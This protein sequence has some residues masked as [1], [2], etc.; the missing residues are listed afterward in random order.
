MSRKISELVG[1]DDILLVEEFSSDGLIATLAEAYHSQWKREKIS[2]GWCFAETL[3]TQLK[4]HPFLCSYLKLSETAKIQFF[5][6]AVESFSVKKSKRINGR[7]DSLNSKA[8]ISNSEPSSKKLLSKIL[9]LSNSNTAEIT[10]FW[11][12]HDEKAWKSNLEAYYQFGRLFLTKAEPLLAYD[13]FNEGLKAAHLSQ[14]NT[15]QNQ[16]W[17]IKI[18]QQQALALAESGA[19]EE[20]KKI[21]HGLMPFGGRLERE[22]DSETLGLLGR[23]YKH[24]GLSDELADKSKAEYFVKSY[25]YYYK[26][27]QNAIS[28]S[29]F[30]DA[31]YSGINAATVAL[32]CGKRKVSSELAGE[33]IFICNKLLQN[34]ESEQCATS[35]WLLGSLAEAQLLQCNLQEAN[36][37]YH[38]A[39]HLMKDDI[40][41]QISMY[42]QAKSICRALKINSKSLDSL[43]RV[44]TILC[45][46]VKLSEAI[47]I[48]NQDIE[49][50]VLEKIQQQIEKYDRI[51]AYASAKNAYEVLFLETVIR[52]GGEVNITLPFD[53]ATVKKECFS[54]EENEGWLQRFDNL[55]TSAASVKILSQYDVNSID[56]VNDF[57]QRFVN[58]QAQIRAELFKVHIEQMT[59]SVGDNAEHEIL[60]CSEDGIG[61][62]NSLSCSTT[63][64]GEQSSITSYCKQVNQSEV[65]YYSYLPL[66]FADVEGYSQLNDC[67]LVI[68]STVFWSKVED[69]LSRFKS[70]I[71]NA[72]TQGDGL[73]AVFDS[74]EVAAL[75]ANKLKS[76][77]NDTDWT[78]FGLPEKLAIRIS[79]DAGP[80][81][82]FVDPVTGKLDFCGHYVNRAARIEPITPPGHIYASETFVAIARAENIGL[83]CFSYAGQ[84]TLPKNH[85]IIPVYH[86]YSRQ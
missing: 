7:G 47:D 26:G 55:I 86:M 14:N 33:V 44:P 66:I 62:D 20:A 51:I 74:L 65:T 50:L 5:D 30:E 11:K 75:F 83:F 82:S 49:N 64:G 85:G 77:V 9:Q 16:G 61:H 81:C 71:L 52:K 54:G 53:T 34:S 21:L 59:V 60:I 39:F 58:G 73:F 36:V 6:S 22:L 32:F 2:Q 17:N 69:V 4:R 23:I 76:I 72:R 38:R 78:D 63:G 56:S 18:A 70:H 42:N 12:S 19:I 15:K 37:N 43:F 1:A 41:A 24:L 13:V 28:Q 84:I 25:D 3:D 46:S 40:R 80:C 68:F 29:S 57:T 27:F 48:D 8:V 45:F 35:Y 67:Q 79:L 10:A 31:Y